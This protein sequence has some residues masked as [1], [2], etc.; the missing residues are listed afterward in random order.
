MSVNNALQN[1]AL[2]HGKNY[3]SKALKSFESRY[4]CKTRP[5][6]LCISKSKPFLGATPD[7]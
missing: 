6:G 7:A 1:S 4:S 5:V 3:E 2:A